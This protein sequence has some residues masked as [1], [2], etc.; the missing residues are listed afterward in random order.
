MKVRTFPCKL[1]R[2]Q[3]RN[4]YSAM[5]T[6]LFRDLGT[7][8]YLSALALQEKLLER[9]RAGGLADILL[10]LEHPHVFT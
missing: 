7:I 1:P 9:R 5:R 4:L 2:T 6:L 8:D 10:M 3:L